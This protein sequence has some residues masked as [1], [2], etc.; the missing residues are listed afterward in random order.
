MALRLDQFV[1]RLTDSGLISAEDLAEFR[2][3]LPPEKRPQDVVGLARELIRAKKLTKYQAEA[4]HKGETKGL[5]LG[6]YVVL[7]EIGRGGMGMVLKARH[8]R[9][10]RV[11]AL[12]ML[13]TEKLDSPDAVERFYREVERRLPA[14]PTRTSSRPTTP[15]SAT[16]STSWRWSLWTARTCPLWSSSPAGFRSS[17][18]SSVSCR[19]RK[20]CSMPTIKA[21]SIGTSSPRIC[22]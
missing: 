20:A 13:P 11:V 5:V 8:R 7:D 12:K 4:I 6:D 2:D 15:V 3:A 10:K 22:C 16:A 18:P 17:K 14:W 19:R 1:Q 21:S 9:M